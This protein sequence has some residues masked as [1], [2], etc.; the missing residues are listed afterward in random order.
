MF[1]LNLFVGLMG[2][3]LILIAF[4]G[5]LFKKITEDHVIYN[6]MN[7]IGGLALAYYAYSLDSV[8]FL[9]LQVVWVACSAYKLMLICK[10]E[11]C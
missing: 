7:I 5:D 11:N 9:I 2:M 8:P 1:D 10:K 4:A 3:S 6:M